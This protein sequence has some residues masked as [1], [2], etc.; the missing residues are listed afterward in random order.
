MKGKYAAKAGCRREFT[1][2]EERAVAAERERDMLTSELAD[3]REG[4]ERRIAGLRDEARKLR[5]QRDAAAA[6]RISELEAANSRLRAR[7]K[8]AEL[9]VSGKVREKE[10]ELHVSGGP[11][12]NLDLV[13]EISS[14][15]HNRGGLTQRAAALDVLGSM[16]RFAAE[17]RRKAA[18]AR[19][20]LRESAELLS[21]YA[22]DTADSS[23]SIDWNVDPA[24]W[25]E[26]DLSV[27]LRVECPAPDAPRGHVSATVILP[28]EERFKLAR[29]LNEST[30]DAANEGGDPPGDADRLRRAPPSPV[31][32]GSTRGDSA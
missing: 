14:R 30:D 6:P 12:P 16:Q 18:D 10:G 7:Y 23:V 26:F 4:S 22:Y 9:M 24:S 28:R 8:A 32:H 27:R 31:T 21:I 2:L 29:A 25:P 15:A 13:D 1:G 3:L 11:L 5:E 19:A 20:E 17:E